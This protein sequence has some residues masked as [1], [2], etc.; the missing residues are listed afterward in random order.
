MALQQ[1]RLD[2]AHRVE[3]D[4]DGD[5]AAGAADDAGEARIKIEI[6]DEQVRQQSDDHE[7][8]A[9][10]E[11]EAVHHELKI[12]RRVFAGADAGNVAVVLLQIVGDLN[13]LEHDGHP[14][15]AEDEHQTAHDDVVGQVPG[16]KAGNELAQKAERLLGREPAERHRKERDDRAREDDRHDARVVDLQRQILRVPAE[17]LAPDDAFRVLYRNLAHRLGDGD[18]RRRSRDEEQN[19]SEQM[20]K[21]VLRL[22]RTRDRT[23]E[24][25]DEG[26]KRLRNVRDDAEDDQNRGAVADAALRDLFP[27]P[28]HDDRAG[29]QDQRAHHGEERL[30]DDDHFAREALNADRLPHARRIAEHS[31]DDEGLQKRDADGQIARVLRDLLLPVFLVAESGQAGNDR[32]HQLHDDRGADVGHD[33]QREDGAL[34]HRA[35][36]EHVVEPDE[37]L[38]RLGK[39]L[40]EVRENR[41]IQSRKRKIAADSGDEQQTERDDDAI[42]EFRNLPAID[43][44]GKH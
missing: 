30:V 34:E 21:A 23:G 25:L 10:R 35:A 27:E 3:H 29:R 17:H 12:M 14:E 16:L 2:L 4:A 1:E 13:R 22:A 28:E 11:G 33:A 37:A 42:P 39:A 41:R 20:L 44:R 43:E 9:A 36:G 15:I 8:H 18:E 40:D 26:G 31:D 6:V 19:H 7:E 32:A 38:A 5:E 24:N